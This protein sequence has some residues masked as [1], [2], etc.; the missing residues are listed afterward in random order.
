M[1][2]AE[3]IQ[4]GENQSYPASVAIGRSKDSDAVGSEAKNDRKTRDVGGNRPKRSH[5]YPLFSKVKQRLAGGD[6]EILPR[7]TDV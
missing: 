5:V 2:E 4:V 1:S 6:R 7:V 3:G